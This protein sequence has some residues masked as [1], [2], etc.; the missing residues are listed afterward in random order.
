MYLLCS[1]T[2]WLTD[3]P[4]RFHAQASSC[5]YTLINRVCL[6]G[7]SSNLFVGTYL[8]TIQY[9]RY[10]FDVLPQVFLLP[11]AL[12]GC[13]VWVVTLYCLQVQQR[14][15]GAST[16]RNSCELISLFGCPHTCPLGNSSSSLV[17]HMAF[18]THPSATA[19]HSWP[20]NRTVPLANVEMSPC[21]PPPR[22]WLK[23]EAFGELTVQAFSSFWFLS[24]SW[25]A[26]K[27]GFC[28]P[29]LIAIATTVHKGTRECGRFCKLVNSIDQ[30]T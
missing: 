21:T 8:S 27:T 18:R 14:R 22:R 3:L 16:S 25:K 26:V 23:R 20:P 28:F 9:S 19:L 11:L 29:A 17:T 1:Q 5:P 7:T 24:T 13:P 30:D 6:P 15:K 4:F 12:L 2:S 10:G